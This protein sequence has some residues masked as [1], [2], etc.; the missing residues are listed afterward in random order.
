MGGSDE[1]MGEGGGNGSGVTIWH[2][3][4]T[5]GPFELR[6]PAAGDEDQGRQ[7]LP[8]GVSKG[9]KE[10]LEQSG[11]ASRLQAL[12]VSSSGLKVGVR[13]NGQEVCGRQSKTWNRR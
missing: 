5:N 4:S 13:G 9:A 7:R 2:A 3:P 6:L 1:G 11:A 8:G 12:G 10:T